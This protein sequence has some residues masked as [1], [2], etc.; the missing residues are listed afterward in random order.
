MIFE[1]TTLCKLTK[2]IIESWEQEQITLPD[3][4]PVIN[5]DTQHENE[6]RIQLNIN[7]FRE[8][9]NQFPGK[10]ILS[11]R[12]KQKQWTKEMDRLLEEVLWQEPLLSVDKAMSKESLED[13]QEQIKVFIRRV[14]RFDKKLSM[15]DMGQA[16]RNY[17]VYAIFRKLKEMPQICTNASFGYS[18][19]Y[20]YTDNYIDNPKRSAEDKKHYNTLI[21]EKL[22]KGTSK[23]ACKHE[24]KTLE[25]LSAIEEDYKRP[26]EIYQ[27]LLY[28][29]EAQKE[30]QK[31]GEHK[32][33]LTK[34]EI[35]EISV[36]KG[37]LSVLIDR[38][39][40]NV[41]FTE[42][43]LYFY[44][45]FGFLLQLCDDLQDIGQDREEGSR[46]IFS[47]C[48]T[49]GET[50]QMVNRLFHYTKN[51]FAYCDCA[52]KE[53]KEFLLCNC[54]RLILFSAAGSAK[55]F[56]EEWLAWAQER[57]PVSMEYFKTIRKSFAGEALLKNEKGY[58][59]MIDAMVCEK[60][61]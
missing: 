19:L 2:Q 55:Y 44:Y 7:R 1:K 16:V 52:S 60:I 15:A 41:P 5:Q 58:L 27:G 3:N 36:Y 39:Y 23:A 51:L 48:R 30:S 31:Q 9:I 54:Y 59:R 37:G 53:F 32:L 45:G 10:G 11:G 34:E 49:T 17:I 33:M 50:E 24:V 35:E 8:H 47:V 18:M 13:F 38:Y 20:P 57:L 14:R 6:K 43:D 12:G 28:M 46:T 22:L 42:N 61:S 29:L 56:S 40:V 26:D 4:L 25:L 21:Y